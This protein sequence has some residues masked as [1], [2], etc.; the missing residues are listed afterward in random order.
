MS[1][2]NGPDSYISTILGVFAFLFLVLFGVTSNSLAIYYFS[3][4]LHTHILSRVFCAISATDLLTSVLTLFVSL[5]YCEGRSPSLFSNSAFREFWGI[6]WNFTSRYSVYLVAFISIARTVKIFFPL[7][8]LKSYLLN[9]GL[10][11]YAIFL[12]ATTPTF[13]NI[14]HYYKS[15]WC[16]VALNKSKFVNAHNT[17]YYLIV[18]SIPAGNLLPLP[19]VIISAAACLIKIR[20]HLRHI[21]NTLQD[22]P[23]SPAANLHV[24][25]TDGAVKSAVTIVLFALIYVILNTP[26]C[27][28]YL[29]V[30]I[31]SALLSLPPHLV[32]PPGTHLKRYLTGVTHVLSISLNAALN[33]VLYYWRMRDF[34][35]YVNGMMGRNVR[36][37]RTLWTSR[38]GEL[39]DVA[40]GETEL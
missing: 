25:R 23:R 40:Q 27:V 11:W 5:C 21:S 13:Y 14:N 6:L 8:S 32:I 33:P 3:R 34:R 4:R 15:E 9:L 30:Q 22:G 24:S 36:L 10:A 18:M 31:Q 28:I 7:Y 37:A 29:H 38:A 20:N 19:L 26:Y 39:D 16:A 12:I 1:V 2:E 35:V 17:E